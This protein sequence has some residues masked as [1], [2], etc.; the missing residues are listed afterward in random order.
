MN[1]A[2]FGGYGGDSSGWKEVPSC[3]GGDDDGDGVDGGVLVQVL[4]MMVVIAQVQ[5]VDRYSPEELDRNLGELWLG[6]ETKS[7]REVRT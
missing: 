1:H 7:A 5:V 4:V 3:A 6:T 2:C